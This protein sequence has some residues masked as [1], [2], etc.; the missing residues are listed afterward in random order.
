MLRNS[1]ARADRFNSIPYNMSTIHFV[2]R[3]RNL[4]SFR[5]TVYHVA[6]HR[7]RRVAR[8]QPRG[9]RVWTS[10]EGASSRHGYTLIRDRRPR[11]IEQR[12]EVATAPIL[13]TLPHQPR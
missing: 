4:A 9:L 12:G 13:R 6:R 7:G 3:Q 11:P 5:R 8:H 2:I 10:Y 1:R